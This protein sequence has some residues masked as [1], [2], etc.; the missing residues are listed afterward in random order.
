VIAGFG[1]RGELPLPLSLPLP[2]PFFLPCARSLRAPARPRPSGGLPHG[3]APVPLRV[4]APAAARPRW[5]PHPS[6][7][8]GG[9][10]RWPRSPA[11]P[12]PARP[13]T[14]HPRA[15]VVVPASPWLVPRRGLACPHAAR[16]LPAHAACSRARDCS[17]TTFNFQFN[18][19]FILV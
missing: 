9:S 19:F 5:P 4:C 14:P 12:R 7:P 2:L 16:V 18:P 17:C 1:P 13:A 10:P 3:F 6:L 15:L 11:A 8:G